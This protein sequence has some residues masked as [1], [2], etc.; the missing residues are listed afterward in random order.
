MDFSKF[1]DDN[2]DMKEWINNAL[3]RH[4]DSTTSVD[5]HTSN[6]VMKLQLFIQEV[7]KSLEETSQVALNNIPRV[8]REVESIKTETSLLKN[9]MMMVKD[10]IR[11][12]EEDT[13]QSMRRLVEIDEVKSRMQGA[14]NALKEADNWS[15]L[16]SEVDEYFEEGDISQIADKLIGMQKSLQ[17]L[18]DVPDYSERSRMLENLKNRLEALLSTKLVKTFN[19]HDLD[20]AKYY[21]NIFSELDRLSQLQTYYNNC[22]KSSLMRTWSEIRDDPNQSILSWLPTFFDHL[23]ALWH[24]EITW[25]GQVFPEPVRALCS[26]LAQT[27]K[28]LHP[29]MQNC[30]KDSLNEEE[31]SLQL[32][33]QLQVITQ[34][35]VQ[36][37]EKAVEMFQATPNK[38][39]D[40]LCELIDVV[41][42]PYSSYLLQ[43]STLQQTTLME[44]LDSLTMNTKDLADTAES[45]L[46]SI[47]QAFRASGEALE[48]CVKFTNGYGSAGLMEA[49]QIFFSAYFGRLDCVLVDL[50]KHC[51]L[52]DDSHHADDDS[53]NQ[54]SNFQHAF[55]I[56]EICGVLMT[57]MEEFRIKLSTELQKELTNIF[58]ESHSQ[59]RYNENYLKASRPMEWD[60]VVELH[61]K[62]IS[63]GVEAVLPLTRDNIAKLNEHALK[64]AFDVIFIHLRRQLL[65]VPNLPIWCESER[66]AV[67]GELPTFSLSPL[68]YITHVGDSLLTLPQQLEQYFSQDNESLIIALKAGRIPYQ[69]AGNST[70][71]HY[72]HHWLESFAFGAVNVYTESIL[73][74]K[75]LTGHSRR[76][77]SADIDYFFNILAALEIQ[78]S[79][80]LKTIEE[81][82]EV[83][84]KS[85]QEK[86]TEPSSDQNLV[87]TI[88]KIRNIPL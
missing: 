63:N 5:V 8:L 45:M 30:I 25:C 11:K 80:E 23:L 13:A 59:S 53:S 56:I 86:A 9:Q 50:R 37:L 39:N 49:L 47:S 38:F 70:G 78:P 61:E 58:Q 36:G 2:F 66:E 14:S 62:F 1:S 6:L 29:S 33:I 7:S 20:D 34:R 18:Q 77:L 73:K 17:V 16:S 76:Q 57:K 88:L 51:H 15:T 22:H 19:N 31:N 24:R 26:L 79:D 65:A 68:P 41:Q 46:D 10:D 3:R 60:K 42:S 67:D 28:S 71:A 69:D 12:V 48:S 40:A 87:K 82:L 64:F 83:D 43:Y 4:S 44:V 52:D 54:W 72:D 85:L 75:L 35:F 84:A 21:V 32:L 74:I 55:K 81:L 27:I